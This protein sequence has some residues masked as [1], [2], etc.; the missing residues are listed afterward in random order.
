MATYLVSNGNSIQCQS[1]AAKPYLKVSNAYLQLTS[2][3]RTDGYHVTGDN[4][5]VY[6]VVQSSTSS[7]TTTSQVDTTA[8]YSYSISGIAYYKAS[9]TYATMNVRDISSYGGYRSIYV[10]LSTAGG[11]EHRLRTITLYHTSTN[12]DGSSTTYTISFSGG[13]YY[14]RYAS[15]VPSALTNSSYWDSSCSLIMNDYI[16]K[17]SDYS[18]G[19]SSRYYW[20]ALVGTY[21]P[22]TGSYSSTAYHRTTRHTS[23]YWWL[24]TYNYEQLGTKY[25]YYE[26]STNTGSF[27]YTA[28][29]TTTSVEIT[30]T[31]SYTF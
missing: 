1:S 16:L 21:Y 19:V 26:T 5:S 11:F 22:S 15:K 28:K 25:V 14:Y 4:N 30:T 31:S 12:S 3:T 27:D 17:T 6:Q 18:S 10:S 7:M 24:Y 8:G 29:T 13:S 2:V 9:R 20:Y 23:Y